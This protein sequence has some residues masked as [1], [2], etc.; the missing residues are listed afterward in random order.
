MNKS[1][2]EWT[3]ATWNPVTGCTEV[4]PGCDHCYARTFAMRWHGVVG[5]PYERGFEVVLRP[6]RLEQPLAWRRP[7]RIFVNS[8]S[9]LFHAQVPEAFIRD[10]FATMRRAPQHLFQIL[11]KRADRLERVIGR[12]NVPENVWIGVSVESEAF[13][14]RIRHLQR[15]QA[16]VKFLSCEPLLGPMTALPLDGI[17]WVI[18]GGESGGGARPMDASWVRSIHRQCEARRVPFFFKQW[19]GPNKKRTGRLLDGRTWDEM[20][21]RV[22]LGTIGVSTNYPF[23]MD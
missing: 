15:V 9:D 23:A 7:R 5:H 17:D 11:T 21:P 4:S 22:P 19:G 13:Y 14:S 18:V 12:I 8:M 16:P 2:I 10:V 6:E 20:P 1:S 3:D